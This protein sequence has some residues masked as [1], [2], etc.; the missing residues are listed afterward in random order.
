MSC[1]AEASERT[2]RDRAARG[3]QTINKASNPS[4]LSPSAVPLITARR[5][6]GPPAL[7]AILHVS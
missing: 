6:T 4:R 3:M 5:G 1:Q 2:Q 7:A